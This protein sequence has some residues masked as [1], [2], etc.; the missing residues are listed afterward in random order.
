MWKTL[1]LGLAAGA[2]G[3]VAMFFLQQSAP[4]HGWVTAWIA[5][6][7]ASG[8]LSADSVPVPLAQLGVFVAT[9]LFTGL[10]TVHAARPLHAFGVFAGVAALCLGASFTLGL[11][12]VVFE[13][14]TGVGG[15]LIAFL[16]GL[17]WLFS[18][19]GR[20][21]RLVLEALGPGRVTPGIAALAAASDEPVLAPTRREIST[22]T[23]RILNVG[24][25]V[26][27]QRPEE[28]IEATR[29]LTDLVARELVKASAFV[30][31]PTPE[32]VRGTFGAFTAERSPDH[33][34]A[35]CRA[36]VAVR[37]ELKQ[38]TGER[39][40]G[41][42]AEVRFGLSVASGI[43]VLGTVG[44]RFAL[45]GEVADF[46]HRLCSANAWFGS[47]TLVGSRTWQLAKDAIEVRPMEMIFNP[48]A[49]AMVEV[50][51]LL[52]EHGG[53]SPEAAGRRDRFWE[54]V[55]HLRKNEWLKALECF[56]DARTDETSDYPLEYFMN[57]ARQRGMRGRLGSGERRPVHARAIEDL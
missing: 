40:D 55:V 39:A 35:A 51:E 56:A 41:S 47:R 50:Y 34:I 37:D 27:G 52:A 6:L 12:G 4:F 23:F 30:D 29:R 45:L 33:A 44:G 2:A 20:R 5:R 31:H 7:S 11:Y 17:G 22:V 53:L 16:F 14:F 25:L 46:G 1:V 13:P 3:A 10:V 42:L 54:G 32:C 18:A 21:R 19:P 49:N 28:A 26:V 43:A 38:R 36:A 8:V 9:A 57:Q 15:A 48:A 24:E